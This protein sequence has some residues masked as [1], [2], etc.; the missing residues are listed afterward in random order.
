MTQLMK[1]M[2]DLGYN[3]LDFKNIVYRDIEQYNRFNLFNLLWIKDR[4]IN[5][6]YFYD[7]IMK[8]KKL[9]YINRTIYHLSNIL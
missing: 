5:F 6:V 2:I 4:F 3:E 9:E 1:I 8:K 7:K